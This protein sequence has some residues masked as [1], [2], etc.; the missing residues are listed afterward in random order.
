MG[1]GNPLHVVPD[2]SSLIQ[3]L[4][5]EGPYANRRRFPIPGLILL[6]LG[7]PDGSAFQALQWIRRQPHLRQLPVVA[8][9][10]SV[11]DPQLAFG[12]QQG[13]N[14]FLTKSED[15]TGSL[16]SLRGVLEFWLAREQP[17]RAAA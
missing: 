9:S 12:Y 1:L 5:G 13:V 16:A 7:L 3:Y 15:F 8:L 6:D 10:T 11:F 17:R 2:G 4:S 14:S